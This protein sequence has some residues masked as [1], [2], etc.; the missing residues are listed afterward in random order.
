[1]KL[2]RPHL[3]TLFRPTWL[4]AVAATLGA[5]PLR[6]GDPIK[7]SSTGPKL[8]NPRQNPLES[9]LSRPFDSLKP[10]S[11]LG[12]VL[13]PS[14]PLTL[15]RPTLPER[16]ERDR[17]KLENSWI[18]EL[19]HSAGRQPTVE[20]VFNVR[21]LGP[22]GRPKKQPSLMEEYFKQQ[23]GQREPDN[24]QAQPIRGEFGREMNDSRQTGDRPT[25]NPRKSDA[26]EFRERNLRSLLE[27]D[28]RK[29]WDSTGGR[30]S[31]GA[32]D[33]TLSDL[34]KGMREDFKKERERDQRHQEFQM[35]LNNPSDWLQSD[36]KGLLE[37]PDPK[38]DLPT[39]MR[40]LEDF[41]R[42]NRRDLLTPGGLGTAGGS[43]LSALEGS[44]PKLELTPS[45]AAPSSFSNPAKERERP[46]VLPI[47]RRQF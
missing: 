3:L 1:M 31:L 14:V 32:T 34:F 7:F 28:N 15:Q 6:A 11:S 20:E 38:R 46:A 18:W 35:M 2:Q 41:H 26:L 29:T 36:K 13:P 22:D 42:A 12:P 44:M 23:R 33:L 30:N 17:S 47:P 21:Q 5:W 37:P 25:D 27:T 10:D 45:P 40:E 4:L 43:G 24:P 9:Y 39:A 8:E 16:N 19:P